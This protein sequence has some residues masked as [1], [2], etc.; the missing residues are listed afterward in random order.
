MRKKITCCAVARAT[1]TYDVEKGVLHTPTASFQVSTNNSFRTWLQY[2]SEEERRALSTEQR[3]YIVLPKTYRNPPS[4]SYEVVG[5]DNS[6]FSQE[7][8]YVVGKVIAYNDQNRYVLIRVYKSENKS[9]VIRVDLDQERY[10]YETEQPVQSLLN[11][12]VQIYGFR[13]GL[14]FVA[15]LVKVLAASDDEVELVF[16][17]DYINKEC[18]FQNYDL[19]EDWVEVKLLDTQEIIRVHKLA[20]FLRYGS[21]LAKDMNT[22]TKEE[23]LAKH[24]G[25]VM[26]VKARVVEGTY[27]LKN[28]KLV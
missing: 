24:K 11:C 6:S 27:Y 2:L 22:Y 13:R 12:Y 21:D 16:Q 18:T 5:V 1:G 23:V 25:V 3:T 20:N 15:Y 8:L 9:F 10:V 7:T 26:R 28:L 17:T 4:I 14:S 19:K